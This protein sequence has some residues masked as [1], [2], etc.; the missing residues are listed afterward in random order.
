MLAVFMLLAGMQA[1]AGSGA[2]R[3]LQRRVDGLIA[4]F[5]DGMAVSYP[6]FRSIHYGK[7]FESPRDAV[8]L[9]S[10]EG[11][12]GGNYHAEYLALFAAVPPDRFEGRATQPYRLVAVSKIGGRGWRTFDSR[13]LVI[14]PGSVRLAGQAWGDKDPGCCPSLPLQV[15]F[16]VEDERIVEGVK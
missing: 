1:Q 2:E 13:K 10:I 9:F 3:T 6:E 12:G 11:F 5:S 7:V 4:A 14:A 8:V 16:R 15:M